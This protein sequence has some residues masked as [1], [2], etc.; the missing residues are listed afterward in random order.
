MIVAHGVRLQDVSQ[1]IRD[2]AYGTMACNGKYFIVSSL[3]CILGQEQMRAKP[4]NDE[5]NTSGESNAT[6]GSVP[7]GHAMGRP[8]GAPDHPTVAPSACSIEGE[9]TEPL[10]PVCP[11]APHD[12]SANAPQGT[13]IQRNSALCHTPECAPLHLVLS[14]PPFP[15]LHQ[16]AP[17]L[18]AAMQLQ[19]HPCPHSCSAWIVLAMVYVPLRLIILRLAHRLLLL[20]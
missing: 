15:I 17:L 11:P 6:S 10:A 16:L 3:P 4:R 12:V 20:A 13:L 18:H 8:C 7:D 14:Y 1:A 9:G 5:S 2:T 19:P